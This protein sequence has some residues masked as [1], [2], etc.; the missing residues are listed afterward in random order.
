V[1]NPRRKVE[2]LDHTGVVAGN[3]MKLHTDFMGQPIDYT[4]KKGT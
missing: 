4:V 2:R 1:T 3:E